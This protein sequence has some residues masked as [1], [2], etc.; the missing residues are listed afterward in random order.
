MKRSTTL[1]S[2]R[3]PTAEYIRYVNI[4]KSEFFLDGG[5]FLSNL[6]LPDV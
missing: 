6:G 1:W 5:Q 2:G 3:N 4:L